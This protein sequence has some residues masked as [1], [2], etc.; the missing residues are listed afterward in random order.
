MSGL[1][2]SFL[3]GTWNR[4]YPYILLALS[5]IFI[6][7][8]ARKS[9]ER[10]GELRSEVKNANAIAKARKRMDRVPMPDRSDVSRKLRDGKF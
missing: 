9:G 2:W 7:I 5:V 3:L 1:V 10:I 6:I 4:F 8:G